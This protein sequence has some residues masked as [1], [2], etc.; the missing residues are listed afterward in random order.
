MTDSSILPNNSG[1]PR[2]RWRFSIR[3]LLIVIA[4]IA[5]A[6]FV[7]REV[8]EMIRRQVYN[9]PVPLIVGN[10]SRLHVRQIL[11]LP[12]NQFAFRLHLPV[13]Q[14]YEVC[15]GFSNA[16]ESV[17]EAATVKLI[18]EYYSRPPKERYSRNEWYI[19]GLI[20]ASDTDAENDRVLVQVEPYFSTGRPMTFEYERVRGAEFYQVS[21]KL[22]A[23]STESFAADQELIFYR[24]FTPLKSDGGEDFRD[25][26]SPGRG[27]VVWIRPAQAKKSK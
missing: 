15:I 3:Q 10:P 7:Y 14:P 18:N 4:V 20:N 21:R 26:H 17:P 24:T 25:P 27:L 12:S 22:G 11:N 1:S 19:T 5:V 8:P 13:D 23:R 9:D 16:D 6:L 2:K